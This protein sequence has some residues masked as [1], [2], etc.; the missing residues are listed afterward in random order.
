MTKKKKFNLKEISKQRQNPTNHLLPT[1]RL[2]IR[3]G[4]HPES[5]DVFDPALL[6]VGSMLVILFNYFSP[7]ISVLVALYEQPE[8]PNNALEYPSLHTA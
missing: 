3:F 2:G 4:W 8:K 6:V 1:F 5:I 7:W